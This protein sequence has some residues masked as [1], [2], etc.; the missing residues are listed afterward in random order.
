MH[1]KRNNNETKTYLQGLRLFR[2]SLPGGIKN[3]LK[4]KGYNYSEISSKW[5]DLVGENI[6]NAAYPRSIKIDSHGVNNILIVAVKRGDEVLVEYSKKEIMDKINSYFGYRFINEIRLESI[7]SQTKQKKQKSYLSKF[8]EKYEK[9]IEQIK[10]KNIQKSFFE[11]INAI[12]KD[13]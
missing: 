5:T 6:K 12:K 1:S 13:D 3:L 2:K 10:N 7:N 4:K 8:S 11:L 9:K